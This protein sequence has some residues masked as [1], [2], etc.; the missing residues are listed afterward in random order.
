MTAYEAGRKLLR[1]DYS[2]YTPDF[3]SQGRKSGA[4]FTTPQVGDVVEFYSSGKRRVG[5]TGIVTA[6]ALKNGMWTIETVEGNSSPGLFTTDGGCVSVHRYE[7]LPSQVGGAN[8]ING[9]LRPDFCAETCSAEQLVSIAR[10]QVG[11][12]EKASNDHLEDFRANPGTANYTKYGA[13]A[14]QCGWGYQPAEWCG[15]FVSWCAY[16][17]CKTA[18][19]YTPGWI[20]QDDGSWSYRKDGDIV[21]DKWLYDGGRWYVFDGAGRMITGWY[22][23]SDGDWYYL[24]DDGGMCASQWVADSRDSYYMTHTG[25]MARN[26][27]VKA[28]KPLNGMWIY[29]WVNEHGKYEEQWNTAFPHLESYPLV[30]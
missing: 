12:C 1:G 23:D 13:W 30:W 4:Y 26:A 3:A 11:Y 27:Y 28:D 5:H 24:A 29:Y 19:D 17:A 20:R 16:M 8:R 14:K 22:H 7:F 21:R 10:S 15:M 2:A 6:A 25:A 18:H 9:F